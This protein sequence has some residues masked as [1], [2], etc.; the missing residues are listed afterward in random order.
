MMVIKI[1]QGV[2]R[3]LETIQDY[4]VDKPCYLFFIFVSFLV[5]P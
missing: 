2:L 1:V 5:I 3:H 4:K